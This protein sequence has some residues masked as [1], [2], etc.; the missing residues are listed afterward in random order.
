MLGAASASL[1]RRELHARRQPSAPLDGYRRGDYGQ[2]MPSR[3]WCGLAVYLLLLGL[4]TACDGSCEV[5]GRTYE[6]GAKWTCSDGCNQCGCNDG[7][8]GGTLLACE[9]PRSPAAGMLYCQED[10]AWHK[11]GSRWI[12]STGSPCACDDGK[13]VIASQV[14][15]AAP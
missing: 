10:G 12:C 6:N 1:W 2:C 11:H 15:D 3:Q 4:N 9:G 14:P 13:I 8:A 5:G 7:V